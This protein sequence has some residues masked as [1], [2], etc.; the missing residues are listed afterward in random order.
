L[1][2]LISLVAKYRW[3]INHLDVVTTFLRPAVDDDDFYM[4]LP[5]V[6][7]EGLNAPTIIV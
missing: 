3:N 4:T 2:Y 1:Q 6:W 7:P 5:E